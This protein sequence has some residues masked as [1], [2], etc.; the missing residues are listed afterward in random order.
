MRYGPSEDYHHPRRTKTTV[1][2]RGRGRK[3]VDRG[4]GVTK[5]EKVGRGNTR[6]GGELT[7]GWKKS[8][9]IPY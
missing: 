6:T 2:K 5:C 4:T 9:G 7:L 1:Q 8:K 3:N